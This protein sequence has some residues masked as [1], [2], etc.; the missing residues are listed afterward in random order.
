MDQIMRAVLL[1]ILAAASSSAAAPSVHIAQGVL[2]GTERDGVAAFRA[3]PYTAPPVGAL[4]WKAPAAPKAWRG[5]RDATAFG[6]VCPQPPVDWAGHD[7]DRTSEDCLTL[8]VWTPRAKPS[9]R[10]PVMVWFHGGGYTAGAGSQGTYE[11]T[12]LA[13]RGVVI[14]TVNYRLGALGFLAHPALTAES[15]LHSSGNYGLLDQIAALKWVRANIAH[16]GGNPANITIFGQSAGG[17]SAMLL[18]I[19]PQA[20]GL[21]HKAIFESG[22]AL[23]LPSVRDGEGPRLR[24][25]EQAGQRLATR[26]HADGLAALRALPA[27]AF[28]GRDVPGISRAP[29]VDGTIVPFDIAA[30][31]RA[32]RDAGVPVLLGWNSNEALRF[33]GKVTRQSYVANLA[34]FGPLGA[35]FLRIYPAGSDAEAEQAAVDLASDS[36]FGWR[37]WSIAGARLAKNSPPL[38]V[39]Q[40]DNPP[41][42]PDGT[43]TKGAIHSD[44]LRYVWGND[45][46]EGKWPAAD[47][48]LEAVIQRYWV[49]FARTGNPN[50]P[51]LAHWPAYRAGRTA[52]WFSRGAARPGQ[53]LR[54]DKLRAMD[55]ALH[56]PAH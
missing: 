13:R 40:F 42:G 4:R 31:Y 48:E 47:N 43:R 34:F 22:S 55:Q 51:G 41:P 20:R 38:F 1:P 2:A 54:E 12:K 26:L 30:A 25:A 19:S 15:P 53:V 24:E 17:G 10:L 46:P 9:A 32:R 7:L 29:I 5:V 21:F 52:L 50:G 56:P 49:N 16:F 8:N 6:P 18:T 3:I 14:V 35:D 39:Y 44:E 23:K 33:M 36:E 28:I 27:S 37:S 11:G 45:D